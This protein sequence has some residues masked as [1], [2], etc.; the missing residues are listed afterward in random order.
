MAFERVHSDVLM[1]DPGLLQVTAKLIL[2]LRPEADI[3]F[4]GKN[5]PALMG[6]APE[7]CDEIAFRDTRKIEFLPHAQNPQ[8]AV[9]AKARREPLALMQ[10]VAFDLV[11]QAI[12]LEVIG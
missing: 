7:C 2:L 11:P 8:I 10:H 9:R 4:N 1:L 3:A 6:A 12:P 5:K